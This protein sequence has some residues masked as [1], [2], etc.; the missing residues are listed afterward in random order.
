MKRR[1]SRRERGSTILY[2]IILAGVSAAV[3]VTNL[4]V[5]AS[6]RRAQERR[7]GAAR[8]EY[9]KAAA[10]A[11]QETDLR[12]SPASMDDGFS[13]TL[14]GLTYDVDNQLQA[15]GRI[16]LSLSHYREGSASTLGFDPRGK[17]PLRWG[18]FV[19]GNADIKANIAMGSALTPTHAYFGG[20]IQ[21]ETGDTHTFRNVLEVANSSLPS[22]DTMGVT[23]T[24]IYREERP[25]LGGL[26]Y[27]TGGDLSRSG[28]QTYGNA[29]YG[30]GT[31]VY[32]IRNTGKVTVSGTYTG[33]VTI[34]TSDKIYIK[35]PVRMANANSKLVLICDN[36]MIVENGG[37]VEAF[38][39][40][41]KKLE[42][43]SGGVTW[44]G[45]IS[46]RDFVL[47]SDLDLT[48]DPLFFNWEEIVRH[49]LP[50]NRYELD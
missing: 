21:A 13:L 14:G 25:A 10:V 45:A 47:E 12:V 33:R 27:L 48:L 24:R 31:D 20:N 37:V 9:V 36:D 22:F 41:D 3:A 8:W 35:P 28:D 39:H 2:A 23:A 11:K 42:I 7:E 4:Q 46:C 5:A 34:F 15:D 32:F 49:R 43:K 29:T 38:G 6:Y 40:T 50:R 17:H 18:L 16:A 30:N 26:S 44:R 1:D 19:D